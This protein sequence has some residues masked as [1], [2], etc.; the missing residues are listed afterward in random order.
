[1][2]SDLRAMAGFTLLELLVA[3]TLMALLSIALFGGLHLGNRVW[4]TAQSGTAHT[5]DV[6]RFEDFLQHE[7]ARTYPALISG[8]ATR[9][10]VEFSGDQRAVRFLAPNPRK[11]GEM[12]YIT[13]SSDS[14]FIAVRIAPELGGDETAHEFRGAA[15]FS[16][17]GKRPGADHPQW[18]DDW[19]DQARLPS[20]VRVDVRAQGGQVSDQTMALK[21]EAPADC[22]FTP[23]TQD[24]QER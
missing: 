16:Y 7:L 12:A 22:V 14:R 3:M 23:L 13:V 15:A 21:V 9:A 19:R 8:G 10:H 2:S 5:N 24:C 1:M 20:L 11:T 18:Y 6:R 4:E 17:F